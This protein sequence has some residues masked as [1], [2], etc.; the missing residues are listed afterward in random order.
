VKTLGGGDIP[1]SGVQNVRERDE[2]NVK[3]TFGGIYCGWE[4][5]IKMNFKEAVVE[6]MDWIRLAQ[7]RQGSVEC[8][9]NTIVTLKCWKF[10]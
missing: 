9:V 3:N 1:G 4:D 2:K 5:N 10:C 7:T 6:D 8:L